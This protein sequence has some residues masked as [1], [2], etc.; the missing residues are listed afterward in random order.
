MSYFKKTFHISL[1]ITFIFV[2][3][4]NANIRHPFGF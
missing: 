1:D 2:S 4:I 3:N